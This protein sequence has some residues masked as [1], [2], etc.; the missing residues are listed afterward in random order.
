MRP[1]AQ[2]NT[3]RYKLAGGRITNNT[4]ANA[5]IAINIDGV[6]RNGWGNL[7]VLDNEF[8]PSCGLAI[9]RAPEI[10]RSGVNDNIPNMLHANSF[11]R[12]GRQTGE[13]QWF[14]SNLVPSDTEWGAID[15]SY[16]GC[17]F[18]PQI[19]VA[20]GMPPPRDRL[21]HTPE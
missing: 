1:P 20:R 4:I 2:C 21:A 16:D 15:T 11:V 13:A 10:N 14:P 8:A 18:G 9:N 12:S 19:C 17:C 6:A 5:R 3:N 7:Y